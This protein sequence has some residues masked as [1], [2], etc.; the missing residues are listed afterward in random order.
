M[1]EVPVITDPE[2]I[3]KY[4][5]DESGSFHGCAEALYLPTNE[6]ELAAVLMD[7]ARRMPVSLS[8]GGTSITG[9]RVPMFGGA[10]VSMERMTRVRHLS[11]LSSP[12]MGSDPSEKTSRGQPPFS[13]NWERLERSGFSILVDR[14][15]CRAI[16]PPAIPLSELDAI[17]EP[18][19]LLYPPDPTEM[20][21][22][23][24]GT[25]G[26]N[27]AGGRCFYWGPTR[28]WIRR[29]RI[30]L[31]DGSR[32]ELVRGTCFAN[33]RTLTLNVEGRSQEPGARSQEAD[34]RTHKPKTQHRTPNTQHRIAI[35]LP[36]AD[37][38]PM[39]NCKN[40]AGLFLREGMDAIDLFI[41]SEGILGVV[42]EIEVA[43]VPRP[44]ETLTVIAYFAR[45]ADALDF[46]DFGIAHSKPRSE[47]QETGAGRQETG[48]E[49]A[50]HLVHPCSRLPAILSLEFFDGRALAWL[51]RKYAHV[52]EAAAAIFFEVPYTQAA[53][54]GPYPPADI[55]A[56]LNEVLT[57]FRAT[58]TWAAPSEQR[59]H[60]RLFRHGLPEMVNEYA[61]ARQGKLGTDLAVPHER[62]REF[63]AAHERLAAESGVRFM[64]WGHIGDSH[65][66]LNFLA[67]DAEEMKRAKAAYVAL[68]QLA[69]RLGGSISAEHG[70][71]KKTFAVEPGRLIPYLE[72]MYG[73]RG[74]RAAAAVKRALDPRWVL[75]VG[76][77]IPPEAAAW[78]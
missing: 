65:L 12:K 3:R 9:S 22:T 26:T 27:A 13:A 61:R 60:L 7:A 77:M 28:R 40:A 15:G 38:Y 30:V 58:A 76:N 18:V 69:V 24:G 5:G 70:V 68:A 64:M 74:L 50:V 11:P 47:T 75:N 23:V 33:G 63:L 32:L 6:D 73:E 8:G 20:A 34:D 59:E 66:H 55:A 19:G 62:F 52:P 31:A 48:A 25:V 16:V 46:A 10:V 51:R 53:E 42:S 56:R 35:S 45:L 2:R 54:E 4:L 78:T 21:A 37:E 43:L 49:H 39:P 29:L 17:L 41:G 71:G 36:S 57:R 14:A 72:I 44:S 67:E 1:S